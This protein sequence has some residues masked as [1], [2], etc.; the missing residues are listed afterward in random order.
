MNAEIEMKTIGGK[1]KF[2]E[3]D[4]KTANFAINLSGIPRI[5]MEISLINIA[6]VRLLRII[7]QTSPSKHRFYLLLMPIFAN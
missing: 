6:K 7:H 5:L 1:T 4:I 3:Y 2:S